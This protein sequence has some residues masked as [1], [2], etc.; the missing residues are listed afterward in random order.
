MAIN[1]NILLGKMN[2][3]LPHI[4]QIHH[5]NHLQ[6]KVRQHQYVDVDN[7]QFI[8]VQLRR[9][10]TMVATSLRVLLQGMTT[11]DAIILLGKTNSELPLTAKVQHPV[12]SQLRAHQDQCVIVG[13]QQ[14]ICVQ[15]KKVQTVVAISLLVRFQGMITT[16]V[17]TF[18]G[19]M[20][21]ELLHMA[22]TYHLGNSRLKA[23]QHPYVCVDS[24][25]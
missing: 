1:V 9:V 21:L 4:G 12:R 17:I 7:Q 16:D 15:T 11:I 6:L 14:S 5:P 19:R 10:Q 13:N 24:Q 8:C 18:V 23:R 20:R 3:D 25:R 22:K 2:L